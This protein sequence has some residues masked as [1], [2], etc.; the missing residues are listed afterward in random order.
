MN[1]RRKRLLRRRTAVEPMIGHLKGGH[2]LGRNFLKGIA[3]DQNNIISAAAGCN[4]SKLIAALFVLNFI[5]AF[6]GSSPV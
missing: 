2:R 5:H 4:M 6:F 3:G 1:R